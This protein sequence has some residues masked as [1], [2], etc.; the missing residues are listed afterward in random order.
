MLLKDFRI[1]FVCKYLPPSFRDN[2]KDHGIDLKLI[3]SDTQLIVIIDVGDIVVLDGYLFSKE[4]QQEIRSTGAGLCCIDDIHDKEFCADLILNHTPG[5]TKADYR[6]PFYTQYGLGL[7]YALLRPQFLSS[8]RNFSFSARTSSEK[9]IF[10]CFGGADPENLTLEVLNL[11]AEFKCFD[12][13]TVVTGSLYKFTDL[14]EPL[15]QRNKNIQLYCDV[16]ETEM[17]SL[18]RN[19]DIAIVPSSG[20][21]LEAL[22]AGCQVI[23]GYYVDN[24]QFL[25]RNFVESQSVIGAVD[26]S[27]GHLKKSLEEVLN[28]N[29]VVIHK[30]EIDG[31]SDERIL[32]LFHQLKSMVNL[33]LLPAKW[34]DREKTY[35]W[36]ISSKIRQYSFNQHEIGFN[37]HSNWFENKIADRNALYLIAHVNGEAAGSIRFDLNGKQMLISYLVDPKFHGLGLGKCILSKGIQTALASDLEYTS[38]IGYVFID[39]IASKRAFQQLGFNQTKEKDFYKFEM[40]K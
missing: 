12:E 15:I 10:I 9:S 37:E 23:T 1:S 28:N 22:S 16:N 33:L 34:A 13:I 2:L 20:I 17:L 21:L 32:K 29:S 30:P 7:D 31:N 5:I 3:E 39:N 26:F 19:S 38:F 18:M 4:F 14:L 6:T 36:A 8:A 24:Q 27:S 40:S 35:E 11:V 25:Y